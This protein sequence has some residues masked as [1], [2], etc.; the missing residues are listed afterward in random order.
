MAAI[1]FTQLFVTALG[2]KSLETVGDF[3]LLEF[4]DQSFNAQGYEV[5]ATVRIA[6]H[7]EFG[8]LLLGQASKEWRKFV[9]GR[10]LRQL[11]R[12]RDVRYNKEANCLE[13][14]TPT[15]V[16]RFDGSSVIFEARR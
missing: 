16:K 5:P 4:E 6:Y 1:N 12:A 15:G 2:A 8:V 9:W 3:V 11:P 10:L 14:R 7:P 13:R